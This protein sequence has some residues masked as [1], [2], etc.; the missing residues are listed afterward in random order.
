MKFRDSI[1]YYEFQAILSA[2]LCYCITAD[3][4]LHL[5]LC[6]E[7]EFCFCEFISIILGSKETSLLFSASQSPLIKANNN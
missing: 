5:L 3:Q 6:G 4:T 2:K 1:F 7:G